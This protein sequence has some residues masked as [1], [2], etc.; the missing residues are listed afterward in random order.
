MIQ[1]I[2]NRPHGVERVPVRGERF[3]T[4][5]AAPHRNRFTGSRWFRHPDGLYSRH[6]SRPAVV[7]LGDRTSSGYHVICSRREWSRTPRHN[8]NRAA[9]EAHGQREGYTLS[10][11]M[12]LLAI[13]PQCNPGP[14]GRA[15]CPQDGHWS[16]VELPLLAQRRVGNISG[17]REPRAVRQIG[18]GS[19]PGHL[20]GSGD[21]EGGA[22]R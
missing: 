9:A 20:A 22:S 4:P 19:P 17:S 13:A 5:T 2:L 12:T 11:R 10:N 1:G 16:R 7:H 18:R 21:A 6:E 15:Y 14:Y 8:G 3:S